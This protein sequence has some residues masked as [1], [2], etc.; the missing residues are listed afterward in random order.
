MKKTLL[1]CAV[2]VAIIFSFVGCSS[3][4]GGDDNDDT[5]EHNGLRRRR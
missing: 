3:P 1:S 5:A 2:L 4:G